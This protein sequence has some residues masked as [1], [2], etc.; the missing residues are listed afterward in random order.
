[1]KF[2]HT[3]DLHLGKILHDYSLIED[4]RFML[5]Q[6]TEIL[7]DGSFR[8]LLI[9]GDVYDR[10]IPSPEAVSLFSSFLGGLK[11]RR[12]DL[13]I[14]ILSGNHDSSSRLGF[15][16]EL[17]AEL[18]I[19]FVTEPENSVTPI[20][21]SGGGESC[22]F[23]LL[24]FLSPGS[25]RESPYSEDLEE[26]DTGE[27]RE[28]LRTQG[29]LAAEAAIRLAKAREKARS[30]GAD[31]TVLGAHLFAAGGTE[32]ESE[33]VFLGN[34]ERVPVELFSGFD[35]T[36]LGHLHRFQQAGTNAWYSGSPLA[37][38]FGEGEK[39][40]LSVELSP[41]KAPEITPLAVKPKH[42]LRSLRGPFSY[43]FKESADDPELDAVKEDYLE[44]TLTDTHIVENPLPLLRPAFPRIMSIRQDQAFAALR[45]E[46]PAGE[47]F[48]LSGSPGGEF[49]PGTENSPGKR[50]S[51]AEDFEDFLTEI[52]GSA[53]ADKLK[54]LGELL[55]TETEKG[56][57]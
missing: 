14:L 8:A 38:S 29:A 27:V 5:N 32:S 37:Y 56:I 45:A 40:F 53:E 52:Y 57:L 34:A 1:M 54:L 7:A 25:L 12:P 6:L 9:A 31:F 49:T 21:L 23:F 26:P 22:A 24:P 55:E 20:L 28:P 42:H 51:L 48:S 15:G 39:V 30:S 19:H 41:G 11:N 43:F 13:E 3:A 47:F 36:A 18:G 50:R 35:Y 33:R 10:S 4:Q 46:Y 2:I 17:F 16:K 44:I